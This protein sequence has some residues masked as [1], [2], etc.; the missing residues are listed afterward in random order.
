MATTAS[1]ISSVAEG[2]MMWTPRTSPVFGVG[3]D[4]YEA[5]VGVDDGGFGVPAKGNLAYFDFDA[6]GFGGGFSQS[7]RTDLRLGVGAGRGCVRA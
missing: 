6:F 4:F 7:N 3:Y 2:P 5:V 1:E